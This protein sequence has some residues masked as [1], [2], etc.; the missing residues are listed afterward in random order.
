MKTTVIFKTSIAF[1]CS[2][3]LLSC[4][5]S[6]DA[7]STTT[8]TTSSSTSNTVD[9]TAMVKYTGTFVNTPG[10]SVRG[11]ANIRVSNGAY[12]VSLENFVAGSGPDLHVY[13]SNAQTPDTFIDLGKLKSGSG[14]QSYAING[15]PDFGKFK[16]VLIHCQ[17]YN[18]VFGYAALK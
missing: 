11:T 9:T 3:I 18:V 17:Q 7:V 5:K 4:S 1:I 13:L 15:Q 10:E 2:L 16:F 12:S 14:N 8:T 6:V